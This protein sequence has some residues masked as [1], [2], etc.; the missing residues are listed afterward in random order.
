MADLYIPNL[1]QVIDLL[2]NPKNEARIAR[3]WVKEPIV[4]EIFAK[5]DID[6]MYFLENYG[7]HI[8]EYF[9]LVIQG[10]AEIGDCPYAVKLVEEFIEKNI[11]VG[12]IFLIC[13]NLKKM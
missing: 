11:K 3:N 6:S 2:S 10:K 1:K 13:S 7:L 4:Q 12:E 8:I 5:S 9:A